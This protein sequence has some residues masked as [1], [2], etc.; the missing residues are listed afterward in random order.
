MFQIA[1]HEQVI[2]VEELYRMCE[3]ARELLQPPHHV[4][5]VIAR[6]FEGE[7]ASNFRRT[8]RRKDFPLPPPP[9]LIDALAE[10]GD[11]GVWHRCRAGVVHLSGFPP[12]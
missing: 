2:P 1:A 9:N 4:Q 8:E 3:I 11:R 12:R 7:N 10:K 5:R 6:P